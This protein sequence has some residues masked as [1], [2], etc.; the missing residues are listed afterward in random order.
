MTKNSTMRGPVQRSE[1]SMIS[2]ESGQRLQN[3]LP[4]IM[5]TSSDEKPRVTGPIFT[6]IIDS[7]TVRNT[8]LM[9]MAR[10]FVLELKSFSIWVITQPATAPRSREAV[11]SIIGFATMV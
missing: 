10:R 11:I 1:F 3:T 9:V 4:S 7:A 8:K 6:L 5:H 2:S